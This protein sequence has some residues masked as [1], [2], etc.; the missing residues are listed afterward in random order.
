MVKFEVKASSVVQ[1]EVRPVSIS[2]RLTHRSEVPAGGPVCSMEIKRRRHHPRNEQAGG[3]GFPGSQERI[4]TP[5]LSAVVEIQLKILQD[6]F[7]PFCSEFSRKVSF[8]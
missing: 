7:F 2:A 6:T 5:L 3:I 8:D 1:P 4:T